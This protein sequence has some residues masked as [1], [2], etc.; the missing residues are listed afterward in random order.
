MCQFVSK[1]SQE[2]LFSKGFCDENRRP[3]HKN[4]F[5]PDRPSIPPSSGLF[6]AWEICFIRFS[7]KPCDCS[8]SKTDKV[9]LPREVDSLQDSAAPMHLQLTQKTG[10]W[11]GIVHPA[12]GSESMS[13]S[14]A[15]GQRLTFDNRHLA[16]ILRCLEKK[17]SWFC[18]SAFP[19]HHS[20]KKC[21]SS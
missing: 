6:Y 1:R 15:Q 14:R 3:Q 16:M 18:G 9:W 21:S 7:G 5:F 4:D 20:C 8:Q 2:H 17:S 10:P 12:A 13:I 19:L 11:K